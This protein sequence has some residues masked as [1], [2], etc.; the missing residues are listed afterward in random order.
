M[1]ETDWTRLAKSAVK[2]AVALALGVVLAG[3]FFA[4]FQ[5]L[6]LAILALIALPIVYVLAK[7]LFEK[8]IAGTYVV[9][10]DE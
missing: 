2:A 6:V 1:S 10:Q 7:R 5:S 4:Y 3:V 9:V 8:Y